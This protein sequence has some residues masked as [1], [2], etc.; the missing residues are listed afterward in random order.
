M[1]ELRWP[2]SSPS[3]QRW[4]R[5]VPKGCSKWPFRRGLR[6]GALRPFERSPLSVMP[7]GPDSLLGALDSMDSMQP[8]R[9]PSGQLGVLRVLDSMLSMR[10]AGPF[11]LYRWIEARHREGDSW[12]AIAKALGV[13]RQ[14]AYERFNRPVPTGM[15][16]LADAAGHLWASVQVARDQALSAAIGNETAASWDGWRPRKSGLHTYQKPSD[17]WPPP[18]RD[19]DDIAVLHRVLGSIEE[20]AAWLIAE[21][22]V[23]GATWASL[24]RRFG[25]RHRQAIHKRFHD[26]VAAILADASNMA[27]RR[28]EFLAKYGFDRVPD[29]PCI[30]LPEKGLCL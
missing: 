13:A 26:P 17:G 4:D 6:R 20:E 11:L 2:Y 14:T 3:D 29:R 25:V 27:D 16:S 30:L 7:S 24:G 22:R 12:G 10:A 15:P 5:D 9:L 8:L 23:E 28:R 1:A 18:A 19:Q 21:A